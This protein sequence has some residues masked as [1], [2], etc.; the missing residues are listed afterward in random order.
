MYFFGVV[1]TFCV[2]QKVGYGELLSAVK[3]ADTIFAL[4]LMLLHNTV[5]AK[6][7]VNVEYQERRCFGG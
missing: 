4:L 1:A 5:Q 3:I 2:S 6:T 7:E